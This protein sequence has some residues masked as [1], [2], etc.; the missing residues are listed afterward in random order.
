MISVCIPTYNGS[1]FIHEQLESIINQLEYNDEIIISDDSSTDDTINIIES[2]KD[3]RITILKNNKFR[4]P[5]FNLENALRQ[6]KG[7][8][9]FLS[10]QD[11]IWHE[12]K[13]AIMSSH[14]LNYNT[15]ISDC[16][17]IDEEN[18]EILPSFFKI[19]DSKSGLFHNIIKNSYLGCCMAFDR[20]ILEAS[21]PFPEK[22]AMHDI[23]IGLI[24]ELV[25]KPLFIKE[26]LISYRRH[27]DNF[28]P[29]SQKSKFNI[30]YKL[31]YRLVFA[32]YAIVRYIKLITQ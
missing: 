22:I 5:I 2:F 15:V 17:L 1:K 26:R 32:Y 8:Y 7:D 9:I 20:R 11:D 23:W 16:I 4:S 31:K 3:K 28:S 14:L 30:W 19:N 27:S 29:T 10:D 12:N 18:K 13:I 21:L 6:A 24:S 25:G